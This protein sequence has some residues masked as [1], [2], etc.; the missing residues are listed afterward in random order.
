MEG[1]GG[2]EQREKK[3]DNCKSLNNERQQ[4]KE[5]LTLRRCGFHVAAS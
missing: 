4:K 3:R 5:R 1:L 2:G